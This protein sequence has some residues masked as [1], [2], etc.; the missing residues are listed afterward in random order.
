MPLGSVTTIPNTMPS[1][2]SNW[3]P[4]GFA[5]LAIIPAHLR[6]ISEWV[7]NKTSSI[8]LDIDSSLSKCSLRDLVFFKEF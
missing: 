7:K 1:F 2:P 5:Y 4:T 6:F 3:P 8:W